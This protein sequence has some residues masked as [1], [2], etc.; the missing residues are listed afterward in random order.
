MPVLGPLVVTDVTPQSTASTLGSLVQKVYSG[1]REDLRSFVTKQAIVDFLNEGYMDLALRLR[2]VHKTDAGTTT[3]TGTIP[4][5]ADYFE[6]QNLE[7]GS[8]DLGEVSDGVFESWKVPGDFPGG[9]TLFRY[10]GTNIETY[11]AAVSTAY[12]HRYHARP[13]LLTADSDVFTY[14][15][16]ELE[17]RLISYARGQCHYLQDEPDIGDRYMGLYQTGLPSVPRVSG[18]WGKGPRTLVP[19]ASP[20]EE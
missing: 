3:S 4:F 16:P 6:T 15:P 17:Q 14:L 12:T 2:L 5:P 10:F 18:R 9:V 19:A 1:L 7:I 13:P 8:L 20:F 11:P